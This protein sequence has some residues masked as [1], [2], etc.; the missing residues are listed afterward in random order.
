MVA[1]IRDRGN[2]W[3]ESNQG[4]ISLD[5]G[6]P[7]AIDGVIY[8]IKNGG[9]SDGGVA[10]NRLD[11]TVKAIAHRGY[12][13]EAPENTLLAY[14]LA[15]KKGYSY[16]ETDINFTSDEIPILLHDDTIN[17]TSNGTG[18]I[19]QMTFSQAR[20][21]DFG[22]WKGSQYAGTKIPSYEEFL[23]LCHRIGMHPYIELK[24]GMPITVARATKLAEMVRHAG[25]KGK[26]TY[27]SFNYDALVM[28]KSYDP[29]ARLGYLADVT[30]DMID[31]T[32]L[33]KTGT[34]QVFIDSQ[35]SSVNKDRCNYAFDQEIPV[36][37]WTMNDQNLVKQYVDLAVSG[38]TTDTLNIRKILNAAEG[39]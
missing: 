36:E 35:Y 14:T 18:N 28:I 8:D 24:Q 29:Y 31:K 16:A 19:T 25:L 22:A 37:I 11:D 15:K 1:S 34:N 32:N 5:I 10:Q 4:R 9:S 30:P 21:Y 38:V 6:A 13:I 39:I 20:Q 26:V 17:R 3:G 23:S 27:I 12:S 33:L 7:Y 2:Y